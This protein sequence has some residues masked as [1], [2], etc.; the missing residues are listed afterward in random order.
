[1]S[2]F[3]NQVKGVIYGQAIGD[4]LGLGTEFLSK[5]EVA[6]CYPDGLKDY[7]KIVQDGHRRRWKIGDWTDDTDQ[8]L[9]I[10]DSLIEKK[11]VNVLDVA[12]RIHAWVVNGGMGIGRLV[13]STVYSKDFLRNPHTAAKAAWKKRAKNAAPNGGIMRT[14]ILGVW[15]YQDIKKV[16][17]NA[18]NICKITHYDP[19]CIGSC[20]AVCVAISLMLQGVSDFDEIIRRTIKES[21]GYDSQVTASLEQAINTSL[22]ELD[23]DEGLNPGESNRMGYTLKTMSAGF[24]ALKNANS[25][26]DGI[27][28]IIHEGGDADT[29]GAVAGA[30]LGAKY[31]MT[32][33]PSEWVSGLYAKQE[34]DSKIDALLAVIES[35]NNRRTSM[36]ASLLSRFF[37]RTENLSGRFQNRPEQ[38]SGLCR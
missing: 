19:R 37:R 13:A 38:K 36:M 16:K 3:Y 31:G 10:L 32:N 28:Q 15:E 11:Q 8:M 5:S 30:L 21:S 17:L 26:Q 20:V 7:N 22:Q 24:W 18:E 9:C 2:T 23:L 25:Y 12:N 4:A 34:L 6:E 35:S 29:N 27:L 1:M 33:I 14:S